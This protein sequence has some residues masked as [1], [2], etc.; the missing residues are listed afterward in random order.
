MSFIDLM[1]FVNGS[2]PIKVSASALPN[3]NGINDTINILIQ[4]ENGSSGVIAFYSM[5][6]EF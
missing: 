5:V 3:T 4:F 6:Q 1:T 2:L